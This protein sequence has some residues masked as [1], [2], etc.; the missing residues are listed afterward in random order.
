M[1]FMNDYD[2]A[3]AVHRYQT[4][5]VLGPAVLTLANLAVWADQHSD[6]W[7]SWPKPARAAAKLMEMIERDGT[8]QWRSATR[9]DV[10]YLELK[11]ALAPVKAFRTRQHADFEIVEELAEEKPTPWRVVNE[12]GDVIL[13]GFESEDRAKLA[14]AAWESEHPD[15]PTGDEA[16]A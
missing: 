7:H 5:P 14:L 3:N 6:G 9:P 1:R 4:H 11:R 10:T 2:I 15:M 13:D 12:A 8:S 16:G